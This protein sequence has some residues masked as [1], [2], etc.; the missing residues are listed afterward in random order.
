MASGINRLKDRTMN[1][2]M[3]THDDLH[4]AIKEAAKL[5]AEEALRSL[6]KDRPE[7]VNY[8]DAGKLLGLSRQTVAKMVRAGVLKLNSCGLIPIDEIDKALRNGG[9]QA[10]A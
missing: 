5:G 2:I 9:S 3:I 4:A 8:T 1:V 7:Q 10:A 6:P